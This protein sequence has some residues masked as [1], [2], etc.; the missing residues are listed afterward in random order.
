MS[1]KSRT[2]AST[3]GQA[4]GKGGSYR[5]V[6]AALQEDIRTR[7]FGPGETLPS[8][9]ELMRRFG[10]GEFAVRHALR[11]L[12]K[13]GVLEL[14]PHIGAVVLGVPVRKAL[15]RIAY[16]GIGVRGYPLETLIHG[17]RRRLTA[18]GCDFVVVSPDFPQKGESLDLSSLERELDRGVDYVIAGIG[19]NSELELLDRRKVPYAIAD[20]FTGNTERFP[21]AD[22]R[23]SWDDGEA[24]QQVVDALVRA[25][26]KSVLEVDVKRNYEKCLSRRL[27]AEGFRLRRIWSEACAGK[28]GTDVFKSMLAVYGDVLKFLRG[29]RSAK[30]LPDAIVFMDDYAARGGLAALLASGYRVPEDV[31]VVTHSN[32]GN[33]PFFPRRLTRWELDFAAAAVK[34]ADW[35]LSRLKGR[36]LP[37]PRLK[38]RFVPG[39]TL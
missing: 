10:V 5:A 31:R 21:L 23:F 29:V 27:A 14:K 30:D 20:G 3:L 9:D 17:L 32:A 28:M 25:G 38:V 7:Q 39:E 12:A 2:S 22:A 8:V 33:E 24:Q 19:L 35:T 18:A 15:F 11:M 4:G 13:E 1:G 37:V 16:Y 36:R 34:I 6:A 26:V